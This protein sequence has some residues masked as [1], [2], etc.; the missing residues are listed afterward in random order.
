MSE[1]VSRRYARSLELLER[2][3]KCIPLG[4]QTFSKSHLQYPSGAA[5][6]FL[7]HGE[8]GH[9]WDVDG[10]EY[11]DLVNGLMPIL[12]GYRDP[13]VDRAVREQ[14][15]RGVVFSMATER[16]IE[17]AELLV[18]LIPCAEMVRYGKNGSGVTAAAV[19]LAR[20]Y[21]GRDRVA[22]CGY[23]GWQ[24]WYIGSTSRNKGVPNALRELT[25][26]FQYN[27][28]DSLRNLLK[29]HPGEFAAVIMEPMNSEEPFPGFLES[30]KELCHSNGA[31][32]VLDEIITGFRFHI[33]G[34]QS[35]YDVIPDLATFGKGMG[36][37][38]PISALVGRAEIMKDLEEVFFSFTYGGEA[39]SLAA[40][41]ATI[42]KIIREQVIDALWERGTQLMEGVRALITRHE[43]TEVV[44]I[45]GLPPWTVFSFQDTR[46]A[47]LWEIKSLFLQEVLLRGVLTVGVQ[48][49]SFAHTREDIDRILNV[50]DEVL[51]ILRTSI[52]S[53]NLKDHLV[54]P[55]IEPLFKTRN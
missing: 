23:H 35:L 13:D 55:P 20:G 31:L 8:E 32:F 15:E 54:G 1:L 26:P 39:L 5:P 21:T 42:R 46:G 45:S 29:A 27:D 11:V 2:S 40:S 17:L 47:T 43:L 33:G 36:N 16:E 49:I 50:Y 37:G 4:S 38:Y 10:N 9:V 19:R 24:D 14:M 30:V 34:A 51:G 7:S 25:H 44:R 52:D 18:E 28:L 3:L 12:L 22:V 6:F 53:G 41:L 48:S